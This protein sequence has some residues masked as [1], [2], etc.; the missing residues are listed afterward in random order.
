VRIAQ[1]IFSL[2]ARMIL[3]LPVLVLPAKASSVNV[4]FYD[5]RYGMLDDSTGAYT[6]IG[7][8]PVGASGGI[9]AVNGL[10]YL[11]DFG[12]N[13]YS[14][15]SVTGTAQLAG[16]TGLNLSLAVFGGGQIGLFEIDYASSL[17]VIDASTGKGSLVGSTGLAANNGYYDTSLSSDGTS[18]LYT[19]GRVGV[20]DELYRINPVTGVATDLGSTGVTGIAGSAFVNGNLEL[21]QYGQSTNHIYSAAPGSLNFQ[22]GAQ[23]NAQIIDGGVLLGNSLGTNQSGSAPEPPSGLLILPGLL[24]AAA[25]IK[26]RFR[27]VVTPIEPV[28]GNHVEPFQADSF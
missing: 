8:L 1:R 23:L 15:D 28:V 24:L 10:L 17:Y 26:R 19:A 22:Q 20:N 14:V 25:G 13:L 5:N 7:T 11:E 2:A 12:N 21:Y 27:V 4:I 16:N 3:A 9:A 18:L 6:Q